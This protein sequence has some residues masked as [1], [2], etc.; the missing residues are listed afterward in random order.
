VPDSSAIHPGAATDSAALPCRPLRRDAERNRQRILVAADLVFAERG[1]DATLD[2]IADRAGLGVGTVY[3][4]FADKEALVDALF[5]RHLNGILEIADEALNRAD[6]WDG[7]VY[8]LEGTLALQSGHRGLREVI[9]NGSIGDESLCAARACIVPAITRVFRRAQEAGVLR[10]DLE[11]SDIPFLCMMVGS[12]A[13]H[14]SSVEPQLWQRYLSILLDGLRVRRNKPRLL[15]VPA[16]TDPQFEEA[17]T[18]GR[19]CNRSR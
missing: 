4:R 11:P 6:P 19:L 5:E 12:V 7:V 2:D 8:L 14:A 17:I 13:D 9:I 15:P 18:K 3:R 10:A 16:L 1:L